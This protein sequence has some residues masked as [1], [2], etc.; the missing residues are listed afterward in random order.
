MQVLILICDRFSIVEFYLELCIEMV[1]KK[2]S[3]SVEGKI[4]HMKR[5]Q[6]EDEDGWTHI[7]DTPKSK[8]HNANKTTPKPT[9][10]HAGDFEIDGVSYINRTLEEMK[11]DFSHWKQAWE[12]SEACTTL[13]QKL[14]EMEITGMGMGIEGIENAVVLGLGSLQSSRR[15]GRRASATQLAALQTITTTTT[16][17][18]RA[19]QVVLQDP[20]YTELDRDFL[21][22][23][24]YKV[25]NDPE[26][27]SEIRSGSLVFAIHCYGPVYKGISEGPRP[28]VLIGTDV[29][30]FGRFDG[31]VSY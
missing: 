20:Q 24:G 3:K 7:I 27:F 26:A 25:V 16:T 2:K 11:A 9:Q 8:A 1:R 21:S 22:S 31:Y 12:G 10:F 5:R 18:S 30:N 29:E 19:L 13:K 15:E 14:E 4:Q 6:I 17:N 28:A 23:L